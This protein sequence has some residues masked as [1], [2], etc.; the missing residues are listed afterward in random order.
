VSATKSTSNSLNEVNS[1]EAMILSR[2]QNQSNAFDQLINK[3]SSGKAKGKK[4]V[5]PIID[6][7]EFNRLRD[8]ITNKKK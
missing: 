1:L 2:N 5:E 7:D 4:H 8:K 3:Y 6:D